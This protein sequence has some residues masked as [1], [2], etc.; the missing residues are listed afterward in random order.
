MSAS[1]EFVFSMVNSA[2]RGV[3]IPLNDEKRAQA[4]IANQLVRCEIVHR[5]EVRFDGIGVV[6]FWLPDLGQGVVMEVKM[7]RSSPAQIIRQLNR[8]SK[9]E[10]VTG[11]ILVSNR[12]VALPKTIGGKPAFFFSLGAAWM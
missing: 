1:S 3:R 6:D 10:K 5:R 2:L 4:E 12:A 9:I 8:Y 11:L 7:N